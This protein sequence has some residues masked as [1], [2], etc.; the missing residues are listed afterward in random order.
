MYV[1]NIFFLEPSK[2]AWLTPIKIG[3]LY[4]NS[5]AINEE[6]GFEIKGIHYLRQSSFKMSNPEEKEYPYHKLYRDE[7]ESFDFGVFDSGIKE[8]KPSD[9]K[10]HLIYAG[11][12]YDEHLE[13]MKSV[14]M[15]IMTNYKDCSP[16]IKLEKF[17]GTVFGTVFYNLQISQIIK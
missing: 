16:I 12:Y 9:L 13:K 8:L 10:P 2:D 7:K 3:H 14:L 4:L 17:F 5:F 1:Q 11:C 6:T 15:T